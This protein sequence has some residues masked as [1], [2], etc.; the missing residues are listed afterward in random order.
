M[1]LSRTRRLVAP[2]L[3][4]MIA[5]AAPLSARAE[6]PD[7]T[8]H[9]A[10]D[11]RDTTVPHCQDG[12]VER[13]WRTIA[14]A[15]RCLQPGQTLFLHDGTYDERVSV[16]T[17]PGREDAPI[18]VSG[19]PG[20]R[21]P[22]VRG[23]IRIDDPTWWTIQ[24]IEVVGDGGDYDQG[25][26]HPL[27][28][29]GGE[30]WTVQRVELRD[31]AAYALLR[32]TPGVD[33]RPASHWRVVDSCVHGTI[34][35]HGTPD[36][37]PYP[38]HNL[39]VFTGEGAGPGL[40]EGNVIFGA[41]NGQNIKLGERDGTDASDNVLIRFNTLA[42]AAQNVVITGPSDGNT[43]ER[44][45]LAGVRGKE[46]YP[47][48]RGIHLS[49]RGNL[50]RNNAWSG[51]A[52][53]VHNRTGNTTSVSNGGGNRRVVAG[54]E[55]TS[56]DAL[57]P[58]DPAARAH[59][60]WSPDYLERRAA[61]RGTDLA[62]PIRRLAGPDRYATALR[63]SGEHE[64]WG[65][66]TPTALLARG[67]RY[68]DALA[69]SALA[70]L[71]DGPVLLSHPDEVPG[72]VL[73]EIRQRGVERVYMLGGTAALTD[74]VARQLRDA[75][76]TAVDR[77]AGAD[78]FATA[79]RIADEVVALRGEGPLHVVLV[80]GANPDPMRG[81]PDAVSAGQLAAALRMPVLLTSDAGLPSPTREWLER[82][83]PAT[84]TVV[85]G[86]AAV[87]QQVVDEVESIVGD[88]RRVWGQDRYATAEAVTRELVASTS[89]AHSRAEVFVASGLS[90]PDALAAG[91]AAARNGGVLLLHGADGQAYDRLR[92]Y[93]ADVAR[94]EL[95]VTV[96]GGGSAVS[97]SVEDRWLRDRVISP[98]MSGEN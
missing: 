69:S 14:F 4:A 58:T 86:P 75:G 91:P 9:V 57:Y 95:T 79:A 55:G 44:N 83:R 60:A 72:D 42:D 77:L 37:P 28:L 94:D 47:S 6:A 18:V 41:P 62:L 73:D 8:R 36:E 48:V 46:W 23:G 40:I 29:L 21:R 34:P 63:V 71:V 64:Q 35:A 68:P 90:F 11:G 7:T 17:A 88:V 78:R 1:P 96:V 5:A 89:T 24:D 53:V 51:A 81:W 3:L 39:Y 97:F 82:R 2:V 25:G 22:V 74:G 50:V 45:V 49:G 43:V 31:A 98:G 26:A 67:D 15:F 33:G 80:E 66:G 16:P 38:D 76:V 59:G 65:R 10:T 13:P 85:G 70:G 93:V 19:A 61:E 12:T 30:H 84:V 20:E 87:D 32:I 27:K 92:E 54:F 52:E 56:C